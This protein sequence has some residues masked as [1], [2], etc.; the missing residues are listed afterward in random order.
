MASRDKD[1]AMDGLLRRGFSNVGR[2]A[3]SARG[4]G[5]GDGKDCPSADLLAAYYEQ[6]LDA[7]ET[8]R[9]ELHF[10]QC[11]RCR[12]QLAALVRADE[13]LAAGAGKKPASGWRWF[14]HQ[15]WL[16]P[17]AGTLAFAFAFYFGVLP[18][19]HKEA[20]PEVAIQKA[21]P[22][23][24]AS[25]ASLPPQE[26]A[27]IRADLEASRARKS[28][29]A[30]A[31]SRVTKAGTNATPPAST[32]YLTRP[33]AAATR[34]PSAAA[35]THPA[36]GAST[37]ARMAG[38]PP[39]PVPAPSRQA[40]AGGVA[41]GVAR[42]RVAAE[43]RPAQAQLQT[44]EQAVG[45][46]PASAPAPRRQAPQQSA[47]QQPEQQSAQ[48]QAA[49]AQ[50]TTQSGAAQ[51]EA[52]TARQIPRTEQPPG[53]PGQS[54][55]KV[56]AQT[57]SENEPSA[58]A[59]PAP[60]PAPSRTTAT[61]KMA[62]RSLGAAG[63]KTAVP[64]NTQNGATSTATMVMAEKRDNTVI[65]TP[66][67][68]DAWRI[69]EGGFVEHTENGGA[70][71]TGVAPAGDAQLTAGS[72]PAPRTCWLVGRD[73]IILVTTDAVHWKTVAP[74]IHAD[75]KDVSAT[76]GRQAVVTTVDGAKFSTRDEGK[77]W[78][79]VPPDAPAH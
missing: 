18:R 32:T 69:A 46:A 59:A 35:A 22:P 40:V 29:G 8:A 1:A 24:P 33:S 72:A 65:Q 38:A 31:T 60:A 39:P 79:A 44:Q 43:A 21:E 56:L 73:G 30:P 42:A 75:F 11:T 10:S 58:Q 51:Q 37:S 57:E 14:G 6:S 15:W 70:T 4:E 61:G 64:R 26:R 28:A 9:C 54:S 50:E 62:T 67:P 76:S 78:Q 71:W 34:V 63:A 36:R 68:H 12:E 3:S 45:T 52:K 77:T 55:T 49:E 66:D 48:S 13:S 47:Q 74:P 25:P 23:P 20:A 27:A 7:A 41:G 17:L 19:M 5:N 16:M 2:D 53:G